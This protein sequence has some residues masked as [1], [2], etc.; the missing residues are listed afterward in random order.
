MLM[1]P[2]EEEGSFESAM[3]ITT[4]PPGS[5]PADR[6]LERTDPKSRLGHLH[7]LEKARSGRID[8]YFVGDSLT[9]RWAGTDHPHLLAHWR[10]NFHGWN[11]ANFGWSGDRTEHILWR[12][13]NGELDGLRPRIIVIQAGTNNFDGSPVEPWKIEDITRGVVAI[14]ETCRAKVPDA[15]IVLVGIFARR[16]D[17]QLN[18][19]IAAINR[20]LAAY[21]A[22][23]GIR[24]LDL[25]PKLV[26]GSGCPRAGV[27]T[28]DGLHLEL[29][30]YEVWADALR[31]SF[32]E[33]LGPP[34]ETDLAPPVTDVPEPRGA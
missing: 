33:I 17:P 1:G 7:L 24:F 21:A 30:A 29:E 20:N 3:S 10:K 12:L 27:V 19:A 9:R 14:V 34:A 6:P 11:A 26:D 2:D 16:D 22:G 8:V 13:Q 5:H 28:A 18:P 23:K 32:Q 31:P 4:P 25:N 15:Q